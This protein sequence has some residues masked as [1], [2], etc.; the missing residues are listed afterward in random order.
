MN[1]S[2]N[3]IRTNLDKGGHVRRTS[4]R[5]SGN[6]SWGKLI[7]EGG[8]KFLYGADEHNCY[9]DSEV[10]IGRGTKIWPGVTLDG[11]IIIGEN[12]E[13]GKCATIIGDGYIGSGTKI[14]QGVVLKNPKIGKNCVIDGL[15]IESEI[16][17]NCE[18]GKFAEIKGSKLS[19]GINAKHTCG[20]RNADVGCLTNIASETDIKNFD[21]VEKYGTVIGSKCFLAGT[22][23][24]GIQIGDEARIHPEMFVKENLPSM[25]FY[26]YGIKYYRSWYL[27]G[28]YLNL[29]NPIPCENRSEFIEK[30]KAK[31][32]YQF[33]HGMKPIDKNL[34]IWL[35]APIEHLGNRSPLR[36]LEMLGC[37]AISCILGECGHSRPKPQKSDH[38]PTP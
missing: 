27:E 6:D 9:I 38:E 16:G 33:S 1:F 22:I 17:D 10:E 3:Y 12:C 13:I 23:N 19:W 34:K 18:I 25:S 35:N 37:T 11:K 5:Y 14:G 2:Y 7:A 15:V 20:I 26:A 31:L 29:K 30:T 4:S 36:A 8:I 21:G 24:G 32:G 28:Y